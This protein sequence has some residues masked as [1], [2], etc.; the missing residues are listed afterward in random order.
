MGLETRGPAP[1]PAG[2]LDGLRPCVGQTGALLSHDLLQDIQA[3]GPDW[4]AGASTRVPNRGDDQE[5]GPY[6]GPDLR[7]RS[8][9]ATHVSLSRTNE[10]GDR[11]DLAY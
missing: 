5:L 8:N 11:P 1:L 3:H 9:P 7:C 4:P 6:Y 2:I 10:V